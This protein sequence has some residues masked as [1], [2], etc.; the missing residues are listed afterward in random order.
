MSEP[1][2]ILILC[3]KLTCRKMLS[4]PKIARGKTVR[5]R[6]CRTSIK[7]PNEPATKQRSPAAG[8]GTGT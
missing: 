3:P 2:T 6:F 1:S 5:C 8:T 7:V 4:V